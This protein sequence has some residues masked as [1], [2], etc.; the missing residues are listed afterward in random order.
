M[1]NIIEKHKIDHKVISFDNKKLIKGIDALAEAVG[2]TLGAKGNTVFIE[3]DGGLPHV[4]KDG[5]TVAYQI[6]PEC[7]EERLG[8]FAVMQAARRTAQNA[9]DG[10][11]TSTVL[12]HAIIKNTLKNKDAMSSF[13]Q[14]DIISGIDKATN[15]VLKILEKDTKEVTDEDIPNVASISTNNDPILGGIIAGVF[16]EVGRDGGVNWVDDM[17]SDRITTEVVKGSRVPSGMLHDSFATRG[18]KGVLDNPLVLITGI[19]IPNARAIEG[20]LKYAYEA[21]R[22]LLIMAPVTEQVKGALLSNKEEGNLSSV[23][24]GPPYAGAYGEDIMRD[25]A[26]L[27]GAT[28]FG[29]ANGDSLDK[30][31]PDVLGEA[32]KSISTMMDTVFTV[33]GM[34]GTDERID[35]ILE[36]QKE[37]TNTMNIGLYN[38]RL[39]ILRG[40]IGTIKVGAPTDVERKELLDRVEDAVRAVG[41]ARESGI[42]PGGGVALRS[43]SIDLWSKMKDKSIKTGYDYG[44]NVL[45]E[46]LSSPFERILHNAGIESKDIVLKKGQGIDVLTGKKRRMLD[47]GIIDPAKVTVEALVNAVSVARTVLNT[48]VVITNP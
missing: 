43:A 10:T 9:G 20:I 34:E 6:I 28:F 24:V 25:L 4:T 11:T 46:S 21:K 37:E 23:V 39:A 17:K 32:T 30:L 40:G 35:T 48:K 44:Y 5:V 15:D 27:T 13:S 12:A 47:A 14:R 33:A 38:E 41:A 16:K 3:T 42:L 1:N 18:L 7:K 26:F 45:L 22:P 2:S 36:L 8:V 29:E 19:E 31:T